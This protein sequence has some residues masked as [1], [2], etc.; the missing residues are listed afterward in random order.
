MMKEEMKMNNKYHVILYTI[1]DE[2]AY[3]IQTK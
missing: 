1:V 2:E 3:N